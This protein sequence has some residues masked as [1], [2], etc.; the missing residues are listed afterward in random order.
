MNMMAMPFKCYSVTHLVT[1]AD[2]LVH[3]TLTSL[4]D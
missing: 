4:V 1:G 3:S 2:V